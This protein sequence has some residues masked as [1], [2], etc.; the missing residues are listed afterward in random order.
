MSHAVLLGVEIALVIFVRANLDWYVLNDFESVAFESDAF[1]RIVCEQT[2][3]A[4]S[5][6]TE[7]LS[8]YSIVAFV[9]VETKIYVCIHGVKS[10]FLEFISSNL[11]HK[12]YASTFLVEINN[13]ALAFFA[14]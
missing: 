5:E 1:Y 7:Y 12:T 2:N 9:R 4:N 14:D 6:F 10:F 13:D 3:L 8:P 11:V